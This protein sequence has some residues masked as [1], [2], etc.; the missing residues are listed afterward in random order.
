MTFTSSNGTAY[1]PRSYKWFTFSVFFSGV[2]KKLELR[3]NLGR[4]GQFVRYDI[5][6]VLAGQKPP[7]QTPASGTKVW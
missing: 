1:E 2:S 5:F 4:D 6:V 3:V 7:T